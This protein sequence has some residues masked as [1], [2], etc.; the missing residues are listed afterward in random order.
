MII[1]P[2]EAGKGDRAA[3]QRGGRGAGADIRQFVQIIDQPNGDAGHSDVARIVRGGGRLSPPGESDRYRFVF[4]VAWSQFD[5]NLLRPGFAGE[6][7]DDLLH[8][9]PFR[10]QAFAV[11]RA[12]LHSDQV[13]RAGNLTIGLSVRASDEHND[14]KPLFVVR[15]VDRPK[16]DRDPLDPEIQTAGAAGG[17]AAVRRRQNVCPG[18]RNRKD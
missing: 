1:L 6:C 12:Y 16:I 2:R 15:S 14:L 8:H 7:I 10:A 4:R 11:D 17:R 13:P 3:Q 18:G 5:G 9:T